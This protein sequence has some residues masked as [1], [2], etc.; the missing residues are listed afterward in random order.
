MVCLF[1]RILGSPSNGHNAIRR[2]D[3]GHLPADLAIEGADNA[4]S[5]ERCRR[6][7]PTTGS[8][9][10]KSAAVGGPQGRVAGRIRRLLAGE[11]GAI[12]MA[13]LRGW[14]RPGCPAIALAL[15]LGPPPAPARFPPGR[16]RAAPGTAAPPEP[17]ATPP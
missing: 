3:R 7:P 13:G 1:C 4:D 6:R 12:M 8:P 16:G 11:A 9:S 5:Q 10:A 17:P 2:S 14:P 15:L